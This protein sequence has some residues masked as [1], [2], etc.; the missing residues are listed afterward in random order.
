MNWLADYPS[1]SCR[2]GQLLSRWSCPIWA[3]TTWSK[4]GS[5]S[6]Q[7][8]FPRHDHS[9]WMPFFGLRKMLNKNFKES[10]VPVPYL[11]KCCHFFTHGIRNLHPPCESGSRS[12]P[13]FQFYSYPKHGFFS[14]PFF[15]SLNFS[16]NIPTVTFQYFYKV[17]FQ[18]A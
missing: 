12:P 4:R 15:Y 6:P 17:F 16:E 2:R 8:A 18:F 14:K 13:I 7:R 3:T 5:T 10:S 11:L 9:K 1:Q